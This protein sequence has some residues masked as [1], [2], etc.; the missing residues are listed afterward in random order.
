LVLDLRARNPPTPWKEIEVLYREAGGVTTGFKNLKDNRFPLLKAAATE[1]TAADVRTSI[2]CSGLYWHWQ[3]EILKASEA[4]ISE[5]LE[6][7]KW[8]RVAE[9]M[10][11]L[12]GPE[13]DAKFVKKT[14]AGLQKTGAW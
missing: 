9:H 11:T 7:E 12:N 4:A 6:K 1:V 14:F 10:K 13:W 3:I 2:V 5:E 8:G